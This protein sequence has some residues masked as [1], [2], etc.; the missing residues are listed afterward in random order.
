MESHIFEDCGRN[1]I[2]VESGTEVLKASFKRLN[3][4]NDAYGQADNHPGLLGSV[5]E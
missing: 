3:D 1:M 4:K 5:A 2:H